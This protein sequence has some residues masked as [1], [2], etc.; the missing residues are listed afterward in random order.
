[1]NTDDSAAEA[2]IV[3][4]EEGHDSSETPEPVIG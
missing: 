1:M 3:P 4:H 2:M